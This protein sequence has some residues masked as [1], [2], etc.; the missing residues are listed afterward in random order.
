[1]SAQ[2]KETLE[3]TDLDLMGLLSDKANPSFETLF[4]TLTDFDKIFN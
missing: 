2:S 1:M 3:Q 4:P